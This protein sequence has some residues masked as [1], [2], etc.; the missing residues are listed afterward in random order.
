MEL[1]VCQGLSVRIN[2][3]TMAQTHTQ[4]H[5][6]AHTLPLQCFSFCIETLLQEK[7]EIGHTHGEITYNVVYQEFVHKNVTSSLFFKNPIKAG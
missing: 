4:A 6:H 5:M 3:S 2:L 1:G 7:K